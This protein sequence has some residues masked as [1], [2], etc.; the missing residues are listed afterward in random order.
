MRDFRHWFRVNTYF[1]RLNLPSQHENVFFVNLVF[2]EF[3][4]MGTCP[5]GLVWSLGMIFSKEIPLEMSKRKRVFL[6]H[7][8]FK[9]LVQL[10]KNIIFQQNLRSETFRPCSSY[11]ASLVQN[12]WKNYENAFWWW[13][14]VFIKKTCFC[15]MLPSSCSFAPVGSFYAKI[16]FNTYSMKNRSQ[17][18]DLVRLKIRFDV[19]NKPKKFLSEFWYVQY[20]VQT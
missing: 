8:R 16:Q 18:T 10:A 19:F 13:K 12:C 20:D 14:R 5:I 1:S 7:L 4:R 15:R 11:C 2:F 6:S 9:S 3:W 17:L